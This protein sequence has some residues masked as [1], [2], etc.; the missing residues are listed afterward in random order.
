MGKLQKKSV[1]KKVKKKKKPVKTKKKARKKVVKK[2]PV[3]KKAGK[4]YKKKS[5]KTLPKITIKKRKKGSKQKRKDFEHNNVIIRN[6]VIKLLKK[7]KRVPTVKEISEETGFFEKTIRNHFKT[8][9]FRPTQSP[10]RSLTNDV[11]LSLFN[12]ASKGFYK[13]QKLWFQILEGYVE[14]REMKVDGGLE[15]THISPEAKKNIKEI[16]GGVN[17]EGK[18]E[19]RKTGNKEK[20]KKK[21]SN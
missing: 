2:K 14:K 15:V 8:M 1:K 18:K 5:S 6:A 12:R 11:I 19:N 4:K 16:F 20:S 17:D 9:E 21:K 10:L 3:K 7:Y 13:S